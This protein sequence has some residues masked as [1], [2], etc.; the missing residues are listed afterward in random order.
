MQVTIV[1]LIR[2]SSLIGGGL[3]GGG[4]TLTDDDSG[5]NTIR[6]NTREYPLRI[7]GGVRSLVVCRAT[8]EESCISLCVRPLVSQSPEMLWRLVCPPVSTVNNEMIN[9]VQN[10]KGVGVE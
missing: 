6:Y 2:F 4:G 7:G 3:S 5:I 10:G 8:A 1:Y 9:K